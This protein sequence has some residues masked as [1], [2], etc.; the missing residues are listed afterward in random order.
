MRRFSPANPLCRTLRPI[1]T[2]DGGDQGATGN[3]NRKVLHTGQRFMEPVTGCTV[4]QRGI[5]AAASC[6]SASIGSGTRDLPVDL[7]SC[8]SQPV[9]RS[10]GGEW[11]LDGTHALPRYLRKAAPA[12]RHKT[13]REHLSLHKQPASWQRIF[14][15]AS[16]MNSRP[17]RVDD[18]I[19]RLILRTSDS[20][21]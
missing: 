19:C 10:N 8:A 15:S 17:M 4:N 6:A 9:S 11:S 21:G 3:G 5:A 2:G 1:G 12:E 7:S 16:D 13:N 18:A 14:S 20:S